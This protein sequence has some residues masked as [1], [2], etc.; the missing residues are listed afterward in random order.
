M[1]KMPRWPKG[2][3][4]RLAKAEREAARAKAI[5]DRKK[6]IEAAKKKLATLKAK[7]L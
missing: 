5:S 4:A 1:K 2:L 3:K 6:E 7:G